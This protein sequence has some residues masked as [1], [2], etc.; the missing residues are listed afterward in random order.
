LRA[1]LASLARTFSRYPNDESTPAFSSYTTGS[2]ADSRARAHHPAASNDRPNDRSSNDHRSPRSHASG[3]VNTCRTYR[4]VRLLK[5]DR[6]EAEEQHTQRNP[7][8]RTFPSQL[9]DTETVAAL[10]VQSNDCNGIAILEVTI[11][12][13]QLLPAVAVDKASLQ[14]SLTSLKCVFMQVSMRPPPGFTSAQN[15][16]TSALQALPIAATFVTT[17]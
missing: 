5:A 12:H 9:L 10:H 16:L 11:L 2:D 7:L 13:F 1:F 8:H 4:S 6:K 3:A 17:S 14:G 15:C